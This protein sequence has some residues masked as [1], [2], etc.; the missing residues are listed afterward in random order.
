MCQLI[1][2]VK[3]WSKPARSAP[4]ARAWAVHQVVWVI[5]CVQH[6]AKRVDVSY[7]RA[8]FGTRALGGHSE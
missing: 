5:E 6:L 4:L 7:E 8:R 3:T 2:M 1:R